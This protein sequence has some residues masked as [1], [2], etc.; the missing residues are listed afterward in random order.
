MATVQWHDDGSAPTGTRR[1]RG[2]I[3]D[4]VVDGRIVSAVVTHV[5]GPRSSSI[6]R[7]LGVAADCIVDVEVTDLGADGGGGAEDAV[8]VANLML[9]KIV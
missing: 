8:D 2:Q 7:A 5:G 6:Q 4:V 3:S 1:V 9:D